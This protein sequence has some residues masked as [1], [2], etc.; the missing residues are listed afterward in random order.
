MI[1]KVAAFVTRTTASGIEVLLLRHPFAGNQL[2]AGTV[3]ENEKLSVA[4][5]LGAHRSIAGNRPPAE[6]LGGLR[7]A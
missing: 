3:E 1:D 4:I 2:P 5:V 6:S 7:D